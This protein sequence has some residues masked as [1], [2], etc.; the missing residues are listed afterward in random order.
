MSINCSASSSPEYLAGKYQSQKITPLTEPYKYGNFT[1]YFVLC[2]I[3]IQVIKRIIIFADDVKYKTSNSKLPI[4]FKSSILSLGRYIG[5][6]RVNHKFCSLTGFPSSI[7]VLLISA[8]GLAYLV[9]H[10]F[11][12]SIWYRQCLGFGS[13]P[14]AARAASTA[15]ALTPFIYAF[16]GK[17]N[18]VTAVTGVSYEKLNIYHRIISWFSFLFAL[19]HTAP[20][21]LQPVKEGG[22]SFLKHEFCS[23]FYYQTG[24][25]A[26]TLFSVLCF[27]SLQYIRQKFYELFLG[28]HW[29]VAIAYMGVLAWHD[30]N[31]LGSWTFLWASVA[32]LVGGY[33]YRYLFKTSYL[34]GSWYKPDI[35][36][37][38]DLGDDST[39]INILSFNIARWEPGQHLF[40]RFPTLQPLGNHPFSIA[41]L[42][43]Y[44]ST[45]KCTNIRLICRAQKGFTKLLHEQAISNVDM[46][47]RVFLD[48]PY[49]GVPRNTMSFDQVVLICTGSGA[50]AIIP[51]ITW[52][53]QEKLLMDKYGS[54]GNMVTTRIRLLWVVKN[55]DMFEWYR[56]EIEEA[57]DMA[58]HGFLDVTVHYTRLESTSH[59]TD[60]LTSQIKNIKYNAFTPQINDIKI[61]TFKN[62][63]F[64]NYYNETISSK[65]SQTYRSTEHPIIEFHKGR[66]NLR[67][68]LNNWS[69][70]FGQRTSII[71]CG[72]QASSVEIANAVA[73]LQKLI[74]SGKKNNF[75]ATYEEIYLHSEVFGW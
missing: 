47:Y 55:R 75:G 30:A 54:V 24:V 56:S 32:V 63:A 59:R 52:F 21:L 28:V 43:D 14:L 12:P 51:F 49:G 6:R 16:S 1:V 7:G 57:I 48:G 38:R 66:P 27:F 8:S 4:P 40:I 46:S 44:N 9:C 45:N 2:I 23:N 37:L 68:L 53:V 62:N 39:E 34:V 61:K 13:P 35:A 64:T 36:T 70:E 17:I 71:S 60:I 74:F 41:S 22:A 18:L 20:F 69:L 72:H 42:P 50:T 67:E 10:C 29:P 11:M 25:A 31:L 15:N 19:I 26:L 73:D 33:C 3:F 5:Y 58:P 65:T